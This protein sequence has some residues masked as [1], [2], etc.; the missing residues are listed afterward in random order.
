MARGCDERRRTGWVSLGL[1][2]G[3]S[4]HHHPSPRLSV[5]PPLTPADAWG[6]VTDW[7]DADQAWVPQPGLR[8]REI[9]GR[10]LTSGDLRGN[11]V[12]DA[13]LAALAIEHGTAICSFDSDFARFED[14]TWINPGRR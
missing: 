5:N 6:Y 7:L 9:L 4:A 12:T 8:H 14:L 3:I 13:H 11:L 10:L 1:A 2:D